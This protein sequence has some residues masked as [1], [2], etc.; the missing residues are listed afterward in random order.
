MHLLLKTR[1]KPE[2]ERLK[3]NRPRTRLSK[4]EPAMNPTILNPLHHYSTSSVSR[5]LFICNMNLL[6]SGYLIIR[7]LGLIILELRSILSLECIVQ[8]IQYYWYF[9][10]FSIVYFAFR[11]QLSTKREFVL[12][13]KRQ[14]SLSHSVRKYEKKCN[15][16]ICTV[17]AL[18]PNISLFWR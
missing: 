12:R 6:N 7:C 14:R 15:F 13:N 11:K 10:A 2:P 18:N 3:L 8:K 5:G 9:L 4:P 17:L 1:Q 16:I